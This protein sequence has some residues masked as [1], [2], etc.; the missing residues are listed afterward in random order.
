ML[1]FKLTT[2]LA[3]ISELSSSQSAG[4]TGTG[5]SPE[6][7]SCTKRDR[8]FEG[9]LLFLKCILSTVIHSYQNDHLAQVVPIVVEQEVE[10][11]VK[12]L[13]LRVA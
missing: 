9:L 7:Q 5:S 8:I 12:R 2:N 4:M 10:N 1:L 6:A 3:T 11:T 13:L